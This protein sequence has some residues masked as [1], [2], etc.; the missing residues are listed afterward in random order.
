MGSDKAVLLLA[1]GTAFDGVAFGAAGEAAGD[2]DQAMTIGPDA[3]L[4]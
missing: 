1:D 3:V 2:A 4:D